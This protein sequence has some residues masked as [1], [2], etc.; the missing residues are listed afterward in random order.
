MKKL[1]LTA[2]L[3]LFVIAGYAQ[4]VY[5]PSQEGMTL[6]YVE[7]NA[8]GKITGYTSY[9]F[10]N[11]NLLND[12]NFSVT[13]IISSTDDKGKT[14]IA[15]MEVTVRV[16]DGSVFFD[17]TSLANLTEGIEIKGS[18]LVLPS[19]LH[20]GQILNDYSISIELLATTSSA[21]NVTVASHEDLTTEAGTFDTYRI[22][23]KIDSKVLF[24]KTQGTVSQWF[25]K[26][27][28]EVKTINYD[29]KGKAISSRE[30]FKLER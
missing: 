23:S 13:Y 20:V 27:I 19:N 16:E 24:I 28:G 10:K 14:A 9:N 3:S 1:L 11:I 29:K 6:T 26:G 15:G 4:S 21:T 2:L 5:F 18:G 17:G 7:K 25:A 30:L 8:K 22:D 12:E